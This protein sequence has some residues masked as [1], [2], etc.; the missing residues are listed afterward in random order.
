MLP[1]DSRGKPNKRALIESMLIVPRDVPEHVPSLYDLI[2]FRHV[3]WKF[4][5]KGRGL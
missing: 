1:L 3:R 5:L 4:Q 2:D